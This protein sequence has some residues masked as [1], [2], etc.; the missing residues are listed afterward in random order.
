MSSV[1]RSFL[2]FS[3]SALRN[4]S[5]AF[6]TESFGVSAMANL[7]PSE[8]AFSLL[9]TSQG[10]RLPAELVRRS[11]IIPADCELACNASDPA[12]ASVDLDQQECACGDLLYADARWDRQAGEEPEVIGRL[13]DSEDRPILCTLC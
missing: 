3:A 2:D 1:R 6:S 7:Y 13:H 10:R 4:F 12:Q 11:E 5:S 9:A 8:T